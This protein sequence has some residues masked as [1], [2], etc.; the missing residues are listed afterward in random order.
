MKQVASLESLKA[1]G[2]AVA[3]AWASGMRAHV[4]PEPGPEG[5]ALKF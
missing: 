1:H 3:P 2:E 5:G 4:K